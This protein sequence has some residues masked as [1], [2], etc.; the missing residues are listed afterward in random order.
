MFYQHS[1]DLSRMALE[2]AGNDRLSRT[3]KHIIIQKA[4][5]DI[6]NLVLLIND[7]ESRTKGV[8]PFLA[9]SVD[10]VANG[11]AIPGLT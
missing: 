2:Y 7:I 8:S 1:G 4:Q 10:L 5:A 9:M 6:S 11:S 3:N